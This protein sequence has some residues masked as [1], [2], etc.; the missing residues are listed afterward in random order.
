MPE[1]LTDRLQQTRLTVVEVNHG[2]KL[3]RVRGVADACSDLAC[4]ERTVVVT[5]ADAD[6]TLAV[7]N[8]GDIVRVEPVAGPPERIVVLRRVWEE[9]TSPEF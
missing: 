2:T 4:S 8:P 1:S 7:L 9:L 5:D 6:A 3:L